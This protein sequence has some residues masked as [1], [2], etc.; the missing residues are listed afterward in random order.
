MSDDP[1]NKKNYI[2]LVEDTFGYYGKYNSGNK[3]KV[4]MSDNPDVSITLSRKKAKKLV[5]YKTEYAIENFG[6]I[7]RFKPGQR[8]VNIKYKGFQ[9]KEMSNADSIQHLIDAKRENNSKP[10]LSIIKN[11]L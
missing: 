6:H 7:Y 5:N 2:T 8:L 3:W 4:Q 10:F 9:K 1:R 11:N